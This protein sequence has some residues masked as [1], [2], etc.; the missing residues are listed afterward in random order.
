MRVLRPGRRKLLNV[1]GTRKVEKHLLHHR[2]LFCNVNT[3]SELI[4]RSAPH[5][6]STFLA[7]DHSRLSTNVRTKSLT[8][9]DAARGLRIRRSDR[10]GSRAVQAIIRAVVPSFALLYSN[11]SGS[12]AGRN[13][14]TQL[15]SRSHSWLRPSQTSASSVKLALSKVS[16]R[17]VLLRVSAHRR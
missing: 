2:F 3:Q 8:A 15:K 5:C 9:R 1:S 12:L 16:Q 13:G 11:P 17:S 7:P 6:C 4:R 10:I 14:E